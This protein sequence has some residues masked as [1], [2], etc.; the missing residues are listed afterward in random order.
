MKEMLDRL[1]VKGKKREGGSGPP[2]PHDKKLPR[3]T[4]LSMEKQR[5]FQVSA[6][7]NRISNLNTSTLRQDMTFCS[8]TGVLISSSSQSM[9][10]SD[11]SSL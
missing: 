11:D 5:Q 9:R 4:G 2:L 10:E 1:Q 3:E 7:E 6:H 8:I